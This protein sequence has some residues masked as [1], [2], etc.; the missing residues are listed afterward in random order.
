MPGTRRST[1]LSLTILF[2]LVALAGAAQASL[3]TN[4]TFTFSGPCAAD[5]CAGG[6]TATLVLDNTYAQGD[7]LTL[8]H[9]ISFTY[10]GSNK[11]GPFTFSSATATHL[12]GSIPAILPG[13]KQFSIQGTDVGNPNVAYFFNTTDQGGWATAFDPQHADYNTN[14][15]LWRDG[16]DC[17]TPV[18]EP[19]A[20][21]LVAGGLAALGLRRWRR[22]I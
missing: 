16:L 3:I 8:S 13:I 15:G 10:N 17:D 21:F 12:D 11:L 19:G 4:Q 6:V 18:P 22:L 14:G 7:P 5:S 1:H 20:F 9:L 2:A